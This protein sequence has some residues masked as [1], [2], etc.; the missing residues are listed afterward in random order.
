MAPEGK[1][2]GRI[3]RGNTDTLEMGA[4]SGAQRTV[5]GDLVSIIMLSHNRGQYV[6]ECVRNLWFGVVKWMKYVERCKRYDTR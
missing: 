3:M 4:V 1:K 6:E 5:S 2:I